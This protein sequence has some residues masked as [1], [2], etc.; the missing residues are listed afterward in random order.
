MR[1]LVFALALLVP[2]A[3][4]NRAKRSIDLYDSG[5]YAGAARAADEGLANHPDDD[6]LWAMKVRASLALGNAE[7]T[8][9]AY[10]Q[11]VAHRGG[12]DKELLRDLSTATLGAALTSPSVKMKIVAIEAIEQ[13]EIHALTDQVAMAMDDNDDRV[14]ATAAVA[15]LRGMPDAPHIADQLMSS[16]DADARRIAVNGIGRKVGKLAG[17]DLVKAAS[18]PDPRVRRAAISWLGM[19]KY[20][21]AV[22][23][24]TRH[25]K[26]PDDSVRAASAVALARIGI[27]NLP[28]LAK[29]ALA[30]RSLAVRMAAIDLY[31]AAKAD[32]ELIALTEDA[33][34]MVATQAAI[35]VKNKR[36]ELAEKTIARAV[37]ADEWTIRAGAAN[38]L[39]S[40]LSPETA[41]ATALKLIGDSELAVRLAAARA[42][43][44]LDDKDAAKRVFA[45]ALTDPEY[46]VQAAADLASLGDAQGMQALSSYVRDA[47]RTPAQRVVA[48]SAHRSAHRVTGGLVAALADGDGLVRVE[49]AAAL[50]I[51]AKQRR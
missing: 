1:R 18:D 2:A 33:D 25:M 16:P 22:E 39:A 45:A 5:D 28:G 9:T 40:A 36:P 6:N 3:C 14:A 49:A 44:R 11:Y 32:A 37:A 41:R 26:D 13:I 35:A 29:Q 12:D 46:G 23:V 20:A 50:G 30:D 8:A 48:A 17:T 31:A 38:L 47:K 51:L 21:D 43:M 24:L 4:A 15:L 27:G 10:D 42:L 19:I 7:A 34:P